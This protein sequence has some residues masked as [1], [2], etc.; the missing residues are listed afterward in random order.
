MKQKTLFIVAAVVL[1]LAFLGGALAYKGEKRD[2]SAQLADLNRE[3]LVRMHSPTLG[4]ADAPVAI[5]EFLD[6]AC[7][8]CRAF[9]PRVKEMMA[10][11]PDQIRLVLRYAPFHEGSDKLV[12]VLEAARKQGKFWPV[13]EA[14]LTAQA[15][16]APNH[17]A[18]TD[19]VWKHLEG[20]GLDLAKMQA[21]M[22]SPEIASVI[23]QD[24]EDARTLNV[25]K[26][27]EF[28]VNGKPLPS[29]GYEQLKALV[30]EALLS[31]QR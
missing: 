10:A 27:P 30:D 22:N 31:A 2:Q 13:L 9:Y 17:T 18:Q 1:L 6:P 14:L 21:D 11:N 3:A 28:F 25:T 29:F 15:D 5:V 23:A 8:T 24:I 26:T 4:K 7:E 20:L 19:L 16:W 12:A